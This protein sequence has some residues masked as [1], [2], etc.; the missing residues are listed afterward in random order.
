MTLTW[1][2]HFRVLYQMEKRVLINPLAVIAIV[3]M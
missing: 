2:H 3:T 1:D